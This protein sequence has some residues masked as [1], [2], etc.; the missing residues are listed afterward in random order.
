MLKDQ[1]F[2]VYLPDIEAVPRLLAALK[3]GAVSESSPP[4]KDLLSQGSLK[5]AGSLA[6]LPDKREAGGFHRDLSAA[7]AHRDDRRV[8]QLQLD[9]RVPAAVQLFP[10]R[11]GK[12]E[13]EGIV[14]S[15]FSL[16]AL[17][18]RATK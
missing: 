9:R 1:D 11:G 12:R 15:R 14:I 18:R 6:Q 2:K 16:S 8:L 4:P 17:T 10:R 7:A 13:R 5:S 3:P